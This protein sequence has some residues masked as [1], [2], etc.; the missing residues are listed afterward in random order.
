MIIE[1]SDKSAKI[2]K[3]Y[4]QERDPVWPQKPPLIGPAVDEIIEDWAMMKIGKNRIIRIIK[5]WAEETLGR[6]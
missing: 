2:V 5:D 4:I 6:K 3:E 1:I